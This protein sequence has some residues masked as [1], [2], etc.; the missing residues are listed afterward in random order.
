MMENGRNKI[1]MSRKCCV[2]FFRVIPE[3][4]VKGIFLIRDQEL[5]GAI[6][7]YHGHANNS[8]G[9][10]ERGSKTVQRENH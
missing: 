1:G 3:R 2:D 4:D 9:D 5:G 6:V 10:L 8:P 7:P